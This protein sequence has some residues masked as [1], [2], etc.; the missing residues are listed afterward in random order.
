MV[1]PSSNI[2]PATYHDYL[3][4]IPTDIFVS[5]D[6]FFFLE[7]GNYHFRIAWLIVWEKG[8]YSP[9]FSFF[10]F[11]FK[12]DGVRNFFFDFLEGDIGSFVGDDPVLSTPGEGSLSS[13]SF[14]SL[15]LM[16]VFSVTLVLW[17]VAVS[18]S[19]NIPQVQVRLFYCIN[20]ITFIFY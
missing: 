20:L 17:T 1:C 14:S 4:I 5:D 19:E 10:S 12:N 6:E 3:Q 11:F 9:F 16:V 2:H 13:S 7:H 8:R 15:P 18:P